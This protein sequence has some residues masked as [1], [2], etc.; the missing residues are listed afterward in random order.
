MNL[1]HAPL[2][3]PA[4]PD[5]LEA[6]AH[7]LLGHLVRALL[8]LAGQGK[9]RARQA[10][11]MLVLAE[12]MLR[13]LIYL[14][15]LR[16]DLPVPAAT[17]PSPGTRPPAATPGAARMPG[18]PRFQLVEPLPREAGPARD[19]RPLLDPADC[20]RITVMDAHARPWMPEPVSDVLPGV[21]PDLE[22][23]YL[24]RAQALAGAF[25]NLND[26][27]ARLAR[28]IARRK[29]KESD[30]QSPLALPPEPEDL[31]RA[32]TDPAWPVLVDIHLIAEH[33]VGPDTS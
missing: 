10:F 1:A 24:F 18:L 27:A 26:E 19:P 3:T 20:P 14:A 7:D 12:L 31:D 4:E 33:M 13:R 5:R 29:A 2:P 21:R 30:R 6:F 23:R 9:D 16:I 22:T 15:A 11:D 28:W 32:R 8:Q 25:A 17:G